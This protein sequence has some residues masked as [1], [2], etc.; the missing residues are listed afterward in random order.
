[1][2][3]CVGRKGIQEQELLSEDHNEPHRRSLLRQ[4]STLEN[5][6]DENHVDGDNYV[7]FSLNLLS[8][9]HL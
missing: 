1:M 5:I 4:N 9:Q 3:N 7:R 2:G 8:F 6:G